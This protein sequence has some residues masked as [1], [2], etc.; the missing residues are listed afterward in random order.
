LIATEPT[1]AYSVII[2]GGGNPPDFSA[3]SSSCT[4][5]LC[6]P[7]LGGQKSSRVTSRGTS[8]L[9][10]TPTAINASGKALQLPLIQVTLVVN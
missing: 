6:Y 10:V 7:T 8:A 4:V 3:P 1:G 9:V 5:R 2:L